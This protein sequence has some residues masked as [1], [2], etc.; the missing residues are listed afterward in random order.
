[1]L[2]VHTDFEVL[3]TKVKKYF[4]SKNDGRNN[5]LGEIKLHSYDYVYVR[6]VYVYAG[7]RLCM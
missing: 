6:D 2:Y 1:M 3:N 5:K 4:S 7:G